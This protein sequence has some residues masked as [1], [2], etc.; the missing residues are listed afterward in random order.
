MTSPTAIAAY[1]ALFLAIG[2]LTILVSLLLGRLVRPHAPSPE[3]N[4]TYE[5][6]EP[7]VG[8]SFVQFDLRFY[9]VALLF[10]IFEV[11]LAFFF[12]P[13]VI[14]GKICSM[15]RPSG[16]ELVEASSQGSSSPSVQLKLNSVAAKTLAEL[17]V[18]S[19]ADSA[20]CVAKPGVSASQAASEASATTQ[21][22]LRAFAVYIAIDL[23]IFFAVLLVGFAYLWNRGDLDWVRASRMAKSASAP[24]VFSPANAATIPSDSASSEGSR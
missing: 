9:V 19:A 14:Y 18:P 23:A 5:C 22:V 11:E 16:V 13:S 21:G 15:L 17:G 2:I 4:E 3:K 8:T 12:P 1:L 24:R 7:P 6:G 10:I 20:S